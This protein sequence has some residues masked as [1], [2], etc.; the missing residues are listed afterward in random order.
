MQ[1]DK[2]TPGFPWIKFMRIFALERYEKCGGIGYLSACKFLIISNW[3][4][5]S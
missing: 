4:L 5:K 2:T 1:N 3:W